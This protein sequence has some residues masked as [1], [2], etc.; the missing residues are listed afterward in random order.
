[1]KK[2]LLVD[3]PSL[4]LPLSPGVRRLIEESFGPS[5]LDGHEVTSLY[6]AKRV[7]SKLHRDGMLS[8]VVVF[9]KS[10]NIIASME[11][12]ADQPGFTQGAFDCLLIIENLEKT[13]TA[14]R[15]IH[16]TPVVVP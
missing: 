3:P 9:A 14:F 6:H 12:L 4:V 5:A 2:L 10:D 7:I 8:G 13:P 11:T 16:G 15:L 1:M